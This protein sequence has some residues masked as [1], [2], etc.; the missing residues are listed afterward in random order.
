MPAFDAATIGD[1][2]IDALIVYLQYVA[3]RSK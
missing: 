1:S 3:A 2:D